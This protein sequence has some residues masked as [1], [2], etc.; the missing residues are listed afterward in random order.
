MFTVPWGL[1]CLPWGLA[2]LHPI[3]LWASDQA[4]EALPEACHLPVS[5]LPPQMVLEGFCRGKPHSSLVSGC[6]AFYQTPFLFGYSP[7]KSSHLGAKEVTH[8]TKFQSLSKTNLT[9][10]RKLPRQEVEEWAGSKPTW[11]QSADC[12]NGITKHSSE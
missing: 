6:T 2:Q 4:K 9:K 12:V 7:Q 5:V 8:T 11:A 10:E 3:E 1:S